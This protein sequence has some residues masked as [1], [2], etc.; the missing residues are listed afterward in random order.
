M[1]LLLDTSVMVALRRGDAPVRRAL[2]A[3]RGTADEI[4]ISRLTEY[5]LLL[6]AF[7]LWKK[8]NDAREFVWLDDAFSW[9]K[10][11]EV[12]GEVARAAAELQANALNGGEPLPDMDLLVALSAKAGSELLTLDRDQLKM[13]AVLKSKGVTASAP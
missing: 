8:Y 5:E 6:C 13:K 11:Y 1:K 2:E 10:I 4:G 7:F 12:D 9:L 3:R